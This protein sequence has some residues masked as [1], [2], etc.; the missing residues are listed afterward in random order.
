MGNIAS[1]AGK[2]L[3]SA[4]FSLGYL[5]GVDP[6]LPDLHVHLR[7]QP[8]ADV[9]LP[10]GARKVRGRGAA[11]VHAR[12]IY[13]AAQYARGLLA[14]PARGIHAATQYACGILAVHAREIHTAA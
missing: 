4:A 2:T 11:A 13:T 6:G 7:R 8:A 5:L 9:H 3:S 12:G 1:Y 14:V 10:R